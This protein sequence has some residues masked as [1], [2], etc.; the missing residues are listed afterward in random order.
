MQLKQYAPEQIRNVGLFSH[1]GA[2]KTSLAEAM[3]FDSG[4]IDRMGRPD[5][6]A[7]TTDF[8]PDETRRKMSINAAVAPVEW[9]GIK[10][11]IIDV[12]G[13]ADF[14][15]EVAGAMRAADAAVLVVTAQ[16][17]VFKKHFRYLTSY[18]GLAFFTKSP[19]ELVLPR[20][21]EIVQAQSIAIPDIR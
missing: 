14:V 6:G 10:V 3:L 5:D 12:P 21:V 16:G 11:N 17:G 8:D 2:G 15:G 4:A 9:D 7:A 1:G 13:Y 20:R 19:D 18:K